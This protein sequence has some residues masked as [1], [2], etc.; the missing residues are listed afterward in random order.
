VTAHPFAGVTRARRLT[1]RLGSNDLIVASAAIVAGVLVAMVVVAPLIAPYDPTAVDPLNVYA[2]SSSE[3]WL[4][5]DDT[6]RDILSRLLYGARP[7]LIAPAIVVLLAGIA[8]TTLAVSAAWFGGRWDAFVARLLDLLFGL[9]GLLLAI[10][11]AAV[12]GSGLVAPVIALSIANI[13][14][15]ARVLRPAALRE[16]RL[17]YV[18]ALVMQGLSPW[19]ICFRHVVP[20]LAPLIVVQIVVGF[21]YAMLDVA[22]ISFLGLGIQPPT[23]E[24]GLM[25]ANGKPGIVDGHVEQSLYA[26]LMIV[27]AVVS[28][29]VLGERVSQRLLAR[30]GR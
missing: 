9:P 29:N 23:A 25:V 4:G 19:R 20:N 2:G 17:P 7:S 30:E 5:T 21:G 22:A 26:A 18:D 28:F 1:G 12:F 13:P 16:R 8:G 27:L 10:V 24:W 6:G 15:L 3:H 14:Y 11:A